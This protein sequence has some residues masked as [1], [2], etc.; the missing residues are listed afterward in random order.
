MLCLVDV[1]PH[2]AFNIHALMKVC[3]YLTINM[4]NLL[5]TYLR[6]IDNTHSLILHISKA[7]WHFS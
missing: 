1:H 2:F 5:K 7:W 6:I 4:H 3:L